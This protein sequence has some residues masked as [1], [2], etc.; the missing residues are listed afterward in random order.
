MGADGVVGD[1]VA[2]KPGRELVDVR[3]FL[4]EQEEEF[5]FIGAEAPFDEG[6]LPGRILVDVVVLDAQLATELMEPALKLQAVVGLDI[7]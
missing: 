5:I 7:R 3:W 1:E 6:V 4:V 2:L